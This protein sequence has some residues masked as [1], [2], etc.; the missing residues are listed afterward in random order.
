MAWTAV[1]AFATNSS[2]FVAVG[3][4]NVAGEAIGFAL[5][6]STVGTYTFGVSDPAT[7]SLTVGTDVWAAGGGTGSGSI[8]ITVLDATHVAGTFAFEGVSITG[9]PAMRSVTEGVFDVAF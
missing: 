3:S 5:Q 8:V 7:G 6:G 1:T 9:T 2:G 4:A